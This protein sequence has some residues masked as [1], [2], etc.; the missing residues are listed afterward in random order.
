MNH[1]R[2]EKIVLDS[3][4]PITDNPGMMCLLFLAGTIVFVLQASKN[5][6]LSD[7]LAVAIPVIGTIMFFNLWRKKEVT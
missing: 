4:G 3:L 1:R 2:I 6:H 7:W 5:N